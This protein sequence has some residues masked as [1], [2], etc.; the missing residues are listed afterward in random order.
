MLIEKTIQKLGV[1][2][3]KTLV[4]E[5]QLIGIKAARRAGAQ[6]LAVD[7]AQ[8]VVYPDDVAV[9]RWSELIKLSEK[10]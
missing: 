8:P 6:A 1:D 4:F 2:P 9:Y 3:L 5:D 7:N 10:D